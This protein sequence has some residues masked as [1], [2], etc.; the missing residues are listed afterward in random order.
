MLKFDWKFSSHQ[1]GRYSIISTKIDPTSKNDWAKGPGLIKI[2]AAIFGH[3]QPK[4]FSY[5]SRIKPTK[6]CERKTMWLGIN[7]F[8]V[9]QQRNR[10]GIHFGRCRCFNCQSVQSSGFRRIRQFHIRFISSKQIFIF[11]TFYIGFKW[12]ILN[13]FNTVRFSDFNLFRWP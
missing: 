5:F 7:W 13:F 1:K 2:F 3:F 9:E 12:N 4:M 6:G 11:I 8:H 10:S